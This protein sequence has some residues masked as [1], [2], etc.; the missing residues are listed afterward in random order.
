MLSPYIFIGLEKNRDLFG[1][2][3]ENVSPDHLDD[4]TGAGRF[5]VREAFAHWADWEEVHLGR[6][7]AAKAED[8]V[9]VPDIDEGQRVFDRTYREWSTDHIRSLFLDGR[10][11]LIRTLHDLSD[12]ELGRRF[13]H[14]RFGLLTIAD[15]A[16]HILGH[17]AYH[18]EQLTRY[19]LELRA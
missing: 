5:S 11:V 14:S 12:E 18:A 16:G 9:R 19:A 6:V 7:L 2:L 17:D 15:Y 1:L 8:G 3:L 10:R 13:E 4:S